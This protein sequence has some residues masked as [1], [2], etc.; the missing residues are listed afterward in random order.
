ME[1]NRRLECWKVIISPSHLL[2]ICNIAASLMSLIIWSI[3]YVD[4]LHQPICNRQLIHIALLPMPINSGRAKIF[5][6]MYQN[7]KIK[8]PNKLRGFNTHIPI[9]NRARKIYQL[10]INDEVF[11]N[12][13]LFNFIFFNQCLVFKFI[14]P[15]FA[16]PKITLFNIGHMA[17]FGII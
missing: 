17:L 8:H 5:T 15:D 16:P 9:Y 10:G 12:G 6:K 1:S 4:F 14:P 13:C 3:T 11:C 2:A 7:T